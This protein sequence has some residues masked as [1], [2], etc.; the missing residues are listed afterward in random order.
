MTKK[1]RA[2]TSPGQRQREKDKGI[3]KKTQG[4]R[5]KTLREG[6]MG[7]WR[8]KQMEGQMC[9]KHQGEKRPH[10]AAAEDWER[11]PQPDPRALAQSPGLCKTM[12]EGRDSLGTGCPFSIW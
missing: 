9:S 4:R 7:T 5:V 11:E 10:A 2:G 12:K 8:V 3:R 1:I 6:D